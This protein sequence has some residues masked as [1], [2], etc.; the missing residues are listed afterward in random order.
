LGQRVFEHDEDF[1]RGAVG[2][3]IAE[4][5]IVR[6]ENLFGKKDAELPADLNGTLDDGHAPNLKCTAVLSEQLFVQALV[7]GSTGIRTQ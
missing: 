3:G 1:A 2:K 5:Q 7:L 4:N 6:R